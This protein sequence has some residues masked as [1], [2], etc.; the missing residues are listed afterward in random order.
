MDD[1]QSS[2]FLSNSID[3][4]FNSPENIST[5]PY[6]VL[7]LKT[8]KS[9]TESLQNKIPDSL[10]NFTPILE[11]CSSCISQ[12]LDLILG[13]LLDPEVHF[14]TLIV[15]MEHAVCLLQMLSDYIKTLVESVTISCCTLKTFP[16][17]TGNIVMAVF[18][19][20]RDSETL[21]GKHLRHVER[22]LK[23]LFKTCHELQLTY[24]MVMER[25]FIFDLNEDEEQDV[26]IKALDINLAIGE[27]VQSL[28]V[29]TMAE[30]WKAYTMICEN[31]SRFLS[32]KMIFQDCSKVLCNMTVKNISTAV[33]ANEEDKIVL[34]SLKVASFTIKI[35]LKLC[36]IFK[37]ASPES[38]VNVLELFL[39]IIKNSDPYLELK[40]KKTTQ[41]IH[42]LTNIVTSVSDVL[43]ADI[44]SQD[45][46]IECCLQYDIDASSDKDEM[47]GAFFVL[48]TSVIEKLLSKN[49]DTLNK[50]KHKFILCLFNIVPKGNVWFNLGLKFTAIS[51]QHTYGLY[52]HV[53][54][55]TIALASTLSLDEYSLLEGILYETLLGT[56]SWSALFA[57][58]LWVAMSRY[59]RQLLIEQ[60]VFLC[61]SHQKLEKNMMFQDSPQKV[62]LSYTI[63][64]LFD[65]MKTE[66][67][68]RLNNRYN[69]AVWTPIQI[70]NTAPEVQEKVIEDTINELISKFENFL[71]SSLQSEDDIGHM[72]RLMKAA[73]T[74]RFV[75]GDE[76]FEDYVVKVWVK[77][78][79][80]SRML[81]SQGQMDKGWLW[82][83]EHIEA[84]GALT[85]AMKRLFK[86]TEALA[87]ILH[88]MA[89]IAQ[90]GNTE[91]HLV[92]LDLLCQISLQIA[93]ED[94]SQLEQLTMQA[95]CSILQNKDTII[96]NALLKSLKH[97]SNHE[98][99]EYVVSL[100]SS[101]DNSLQEKYALLLQ[102]SSQETKH[103]RNNLTSEESSHKSVYA[104]KCVENA[105]IVEL[106]SSGCSKELK[107]NSN[108]FDFADIDSLFGGETDY[109]QPASKKAKLTMVHRTADIISRL[110]TDSSLLCSEKENVFSYEEISRIRAVCDRLRNI[111]D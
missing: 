110:E 91:L 46:F 63:A 9:L 19:H 102:A 24:L 15:Y 34:R 98:N 68:I 105:Q 67:K 71:S 95:Y 53:L 56:D 45:M 38:Y 47:L 96:K 86:D 101:V 83:L 8:K 7:M 30:Q 10:S 73:A 93:N 41:F 42:Q 51:R 17:T 27:I 85:K 25:H 23:K 20:C 11:D 77:S 31:H 16:V 69:L 82:Y 2:D 70:K 97:F 18:T 88:V 94:K 106:S 76:T 43:L 104:H 55:H 37:C 33:E 32:D 100:I 12:S 107:E 4:S 44:V 22:Q 59:N 39:F 5:V 13:V 81:L 78:C 109:D 52:E 26:L 29:K 66:D 21:Y 108:N 75:D 84:L 99:F 14:Q 62:H 60:F 103:W 89:N 1:S 61:K 92:L 50:F 28:D 48:V 57:S 111:T 35:L 90:L 36:G 64:R 6:D 87:K 3:Y 40:H 58:D 79:P 80:K 65:A 49:D 74:C 72:N 54:V